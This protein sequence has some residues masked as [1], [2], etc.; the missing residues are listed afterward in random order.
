MTDI[1]K[2]FPLF[3]KTSLYLQNKAKFFKTTLP[4]LFDLDYDYDFAERIC[5]T[6]LVA[7]G[8]DLE[9]Y[10]ENVDRLIDLS[11]DFLKLQVLLER[12]GKYKYTTFDEV[13]KM[14]ELEKET[15]PNYLWGLYFSEIF[16]KI[17]CNLIKF[18]KIKFVE[19][20]PD[21]GKILEVPI[22]TGFYLSEFLLKKSAW[23]G[24]GIDFAENAVKF[25][26]KICELN[27]ISKKCEILQK[28]FF[29]FNSEEKFDR[30][31]CGEFL[32]HVETPQDVIEKI[33]NIL[34]KN[35]KIFLTA[36]IWAGGVDHIYLYEHPNEI[37]EQI[38]R[39][40]LRIEEEL[41]QPVFEKDLKHPEKGKIA[42]NY[43]AI[44]S[45]EN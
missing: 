20:S 41:V 35:G 24:L 15:G 13:K 19:K 27:N 23:S 37:R 21:I 9:K 18:F 12:T 33:V 10:F 32:E 1:G 3:N 42:I 17:H 43:S 4:S 28:D 34:S 29:K 14:Y 2:K 44:L 39:S 40:G 36:A 11:L 45:K 30:I 8:N 6:G 26:N 7:S 16:W 38:R 25:S 22:G 5:N 31:I